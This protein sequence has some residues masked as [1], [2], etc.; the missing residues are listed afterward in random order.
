MAANASPGP[1]QTPEEPEGGG[2]PSVNEKTLQTKRLE[3]ER[4]TFI[5]SLKENQRGRFIRITEDVNGRRDSII[6]P[7]SG[8]KEFRE[9]LDTL[10][11]YSRKRPPE[12]NR[13]R[14]EEEGP[15]GGKP[16]SEWDL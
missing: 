7:A 2:K 3:V 16:H 8:L 9:R 4:K 12:V 15:A 14:H 10:I 13:D 6:V 1:E 5:L 11:N